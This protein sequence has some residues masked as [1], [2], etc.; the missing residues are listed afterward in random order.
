MVRFG[1]RVSEASSAEQLHP[2]TIPQ[3]DDF[4]ADQ[5]RRSG[6]TGSI[7]R[8]TL[9]VAD[10]LSDRIRVRRTCLHSAIRGW[11]PRRRNNSGRVWLDCDGPDWPTSAGQLAIT[12]GDAS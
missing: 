11:R 4:S 7:G 5:Y 3:C 10:R 1:E 9:E 2:E 12:A 6:S 8:S